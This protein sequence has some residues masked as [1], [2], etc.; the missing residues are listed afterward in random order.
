MT[1]E[2]DQAGFVKTTGN[3]RQVQPHRSFDPRRVG[4]LEV[5]VWTAYYRREWLRFLRGAVAL[6]RHVFGLPWPSTLL[7]SWLVLRALQRW[8]PYPDN[9]PDGARRTM[10]R[11]YAL[12][13]RHHREPLDPARAA[14]LEI[15]WWRVHRAYQYGDPGTNG[16]D[17]VEAIARLY[18]YAYDVPEADVRDAAEQ[19]VVAMSYS[20][21]WVEEGCDIQSP[22]IG[23][24][25]AALVSSYSGLLAAVQ[26]P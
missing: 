19:R 25:R 15:E 5:S 17:L 6:T 20:D 2:H 10:E 24:E 14:E 18:A 4:M 13:A 22:L 1:P 3:G 9:D 11:F 7:G 16:D 21:R 8:A 23:Q 12:V 26:R